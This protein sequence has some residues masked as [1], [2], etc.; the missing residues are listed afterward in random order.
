MNKQDLLHSGCLSFLFFAT[1]FMLT[2]VGMA[3][4]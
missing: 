1:I 2:M 3:H 4:C